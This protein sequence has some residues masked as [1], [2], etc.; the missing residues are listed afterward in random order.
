MSET[1]NP[2]LKAVSVRKQS[3]AAV[4]SQIHTKIL[5]RDAQDRHLLGERLIT[6]ERGICNYGKIPDA[7]KENFLICSLRQG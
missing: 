4:C 7:R 5:P 2:T 3:L 6:D 1:L